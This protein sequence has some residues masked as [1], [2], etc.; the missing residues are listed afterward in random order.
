MAAG[1]GTR[2]YPL[3]G[4]T[5]KP[6]VPILNRPVMEHMI[7]LLQRHGVTEVAANLHYHPDKIRRYFGDGSRLGVELRYNVEEELLGTAGGVGEFREFFGDGTF[8]VVSG[9]GLTDIDLT[10]F[11]AAHGRPAASPRWPSSRSPTRRSTASSSTTTSLRVTRLSGEGPGDGGAV[12]PLQLRHLRLRAGHL[13]L[14]AAR[15]SS[16][17]GPKTCSRRCCATTCPSTRGSWTATGTTWATSSSTARSNFDALARAR[18]AG[19]PGPPVPARGVGRRGHADRVDVRLEPPILIGAGCLIEAEAELVGPLIVG[20]GCVIERGAVL[21]GV[22]NWDGVKAGR[23]SRLA[24]S[25]LGRNVII[26]HEAVV[27]EDAVIGDRSEV[28]GLRARRRPWRASN[29]ARSSVRT[30]PEHGPLAVGGAAG[31]RPPEG[32]LR[33]GRRSRTATTPAAHWTACSTSSSPSAAC[34]AGPP[35]AGSASPAPAASRRCPT[36][37]ARAAAHPATGRGGRA[38][39]APAAT[40]RSRRPRRPSPTRARPATWSR[41]VSSARCAPSSTRWC[42]GRGRPSSPPAAATPPAPPRRTCWSPGCPATATT[43]WSAASTRPSSSP[44]GLRARP[45]VSYA[46]LLRRVRHGARQSGL[47]RAA[48]AANVH[49][50]FALREDVKRVLRNLKRV[51]IVDDVYTTGETLN[52]CADALAQADLRPHVFTFARTVRAASSAATR[53]NTLQKERCR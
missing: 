3:T 25:I 48:R 44:A 8:V 38:R 45:G 35:A 37:A 4:R 41:P 29:R 36:S 34:T 10:A 15:R 14:R 9:D 19:H 2:L 1:L 52:H 6:M 16:S 23:N 30:G 12:G 42:G 13:R 32:N 40:S 31:E 47:D 39:S 46:P 5:A 28:S 21:E 49:D 33:G 11:V 43:A 17:T 22:I 18:Q 26:H 51:V 20:D 27:H 24:G 7:H 50:A 53:R